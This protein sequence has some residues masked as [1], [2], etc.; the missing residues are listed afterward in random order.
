MIGQ[1]GIPL[2][3]RLVTDECQECLLCIMCITRAKT[4]MTGGEDTV[5]G[6]SKLQLQLQ[7]R[8]LWLMYQSFGSLKFS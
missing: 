7:E 2:K 5:Y 1:C 6:A 3:K 8:N 4:D